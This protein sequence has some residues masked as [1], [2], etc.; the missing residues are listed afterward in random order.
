MDRTLLDH[1]DVWAAAGHP[2]SIFKISPSK[3]AEIANAKV[4]D[5]T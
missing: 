1:E 2:K 5:L 4:S 3:L